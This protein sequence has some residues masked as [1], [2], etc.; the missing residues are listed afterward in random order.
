MS[1]SMEYWMLSAML[2]PLR[3]SYPSHRSKLVE[4]LVTLRQMQQEPLHQ[5]IPRQDLETLI[6][7]L[8]TSIECGDS[9]QGLAKKA[10][11]LAKMWE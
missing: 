2:R 4:C 3:L 8:E 7:C 5:E 11:T 1:Y 9:I 6:K 10:D